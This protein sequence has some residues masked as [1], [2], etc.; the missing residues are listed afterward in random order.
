MK[1]NEKVAVIPMSEY[2]ELIRFKE[3]TLLGKTNVVVRDCYSESIRFYSNDELFQKLADQSVENK[4]L[5]DKACSKIDQLQDE[6]I[7]YKGNIETLKER[8][9]KLEKQ[10]LWSFIKMKLK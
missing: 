2:M 1:T 7:L 8:C 9:S 6:A 5:Y 10:G 3:E 4:N